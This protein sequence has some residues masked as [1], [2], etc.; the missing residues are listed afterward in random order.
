MRNEGITLTGPEGYV[1]AYRVAEDNLRLGISVV[2][3]SVNPIG[4]TRQ[5][6]RDVAD[7]AETRCLEIEI[8]CS[9]IAEHQRRVESR[10]SEVPGLRLPTWNEVESRKYDR[11]ETDR[12]IVDTAGRTDSQSFA[13][14]KRGLSEHGK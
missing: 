7:R 13:M 3:D 2:A 11:W 12:I 1:V 8:V 6:W 9:D 5:A 14:L 10:A 4:V